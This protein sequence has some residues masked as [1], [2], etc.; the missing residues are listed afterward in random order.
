MHYQFRSSLSFFNTITFHRHPPTW[1]YKVSVHF[2]CSEI[3]FAFWPVIHS[4]PHN[5]EQSCPC[6]WQMALPHLL[7]VQNTGSLSI[8]LYLLLFGHPQVRYLTK[9][10]RRK[11]CC[12]VGL[13][14]GTGGVAGSVESQT[15][16]VMAPM[17]FET[18]SWPSAL[19]NHL[20]DCGIII[21]D[22][23]CL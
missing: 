17:L 16:L 20:T 9:G 15:E 22:C 19:L 4:M 14:V 12:L 13:T 5:R 7:V 11:E 3:K 18:W 1:Y 8:P 23:F 21:S 6:I 2:L 10:F